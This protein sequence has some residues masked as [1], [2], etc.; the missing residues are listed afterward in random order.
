MNRWYMY[1]GVVIV[2]SLMGCGMLTEPVKET[3]DGYEVQKN[4]SLR[5][6][7]QT[8]LSSNTN[9]RGDQF[10]TYLAQAL[11]FKE[12]AIL[13]KDTQIR[14][15]V[16]RVKKY[17]RLGDRA[18]LFLLFDQI[19]LSSGVRIPLVASLNTEEG[20]RVIKIKGKAVKNATI[21]GGSALV[22]TVLG[23]ET[24]GKNGAEKGLIVGAGLG[25]GAVFLSNM[26]E[27]KLPAGTELVIKLDEPLLIPKSP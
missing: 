18:S 25:T 24:L 1:L 4:T 2:I 19:V 22:G 27:I 10:T 21:I 26:K 13:P 3:A 16:K 11:V 9:K 12:K 6:I 5:V 14:G 15:L 20:N 8:P 17:E 23:R 7:L